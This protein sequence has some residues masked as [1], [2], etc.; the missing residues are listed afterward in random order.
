M[1]W[2]AASDDI[3]FVWIF[4]RDMAS[5]DSVMFTFDDLTY[6]FIA[7]TVH[8]VTLF[9]DALILCVS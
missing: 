3:G 6:L 4:P 9:A 5:S 1:A 8:A 7:M 2:T